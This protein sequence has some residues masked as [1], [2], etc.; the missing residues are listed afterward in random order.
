MTALVAHKLWTREEREVLEKSGLVDPRR[1][2]L[3]EGELVEKMPKNILHVRS[4]VLL[5]K[6]LISLFD[7]ECIAQE[8]PIDVS[9]EDNPT[10]EP[11]PDA[12]VLTQSIR[13]VTSQIRASQLQIVFEVSDSSLAIDLGSKAKLYARGNIPEYW[14]LD[15]DKR[16]V[17]IHRRPVNGEYRSIE[18]FAE[19]ESVATLARPDSPVEAAELFG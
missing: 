8:S 6:W 11:V 13:T 18:V 4:M 1:Y 12:I 17:I 14:V 2:E 3:L 7:A 10:S 15:V 9:P 5:M 19:R 16:R